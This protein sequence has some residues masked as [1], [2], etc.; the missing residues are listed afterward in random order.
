MHHLLV[1]DFMSLALD[2]YYA[3]ASPDSGAKA[4]NA[5]DTVE[6]ALSGLT[7]N[8]APSHMLV[9]F[10]AGGK[11]IRHFLAE[12]A[13]KAY[14][15]QAPWN[16]EVPSPLRVQQYGRMATVARSFA[17]V[18]HVG[19]DAAD[20]IASAAYEAANCNWN[21]SIVSSDFRL[22]SLL[23]LG[24]SLY[25]DL[26]LQK[27]DVAWCAQTY[28]GASPSRVLDVIALQ[29]LRGSFSAALQFLTRYGPL[30]KLLRMV[31]ASL[32]NS[33]RNAFLAVRK[34]VDLWRQL[35]ELHDYLFAGRGLRPS[36]M[37]I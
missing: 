22:V 26:T 11:T 2:A 6:Q 34:E 37:K 31:P 18:T 16:Y 28:G 7:Q 35:L 9:V 23:P 5:C 30:S 8:L 20:T 14:R 32:Q 3:D 36:E 19:F 12:K 27:R 4:C 24:V 17:T 10:D 15:L 29:C 25:A 21:V 1:V 33:E 13:G